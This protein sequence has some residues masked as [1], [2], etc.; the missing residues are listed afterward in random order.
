M[1]PRLRARGALVVAY[2]DTS[3]LLELKPTDRRRGTRVRRAAGAHPRATTSDGAKATSS[4][5]INPPE[6][7]LGTQVRTAPPDSAAVLRRYLPAAIVATALVIVAPALIVSAL[8]PNGGVTMAIVSAAAAVGISLVIATALA[9]LWKRRAR[10][11]DVV[12]ADLMLWGWLRRYRAERRLSQARDLFESARRA[13][14]SVNIEML[15]G[16][17]RLLE[18][19]DP[20]IHGHSQRVARHSVRIGRAMGLSER[21]VAKLRTAA[22]VHDVGKLYTPRAILVNPDRLTE[23]EF[24]VIKRHTTCGAE[25]VSVVGDAEITAMVRHHH[26]R[27]DGC[28][29]PDALAGVAIPLGAR[30]IAVA[31][32]FDA[33]TS[34]RPYRSAASQKRALGVLE[35]EAGAQLD[36]AAVAAFKH[37]YSA[38]RSVAWYAF[39]TTAVQRAVAALQSLVSSLGLGAASVA[40]LAPA[41]GAAGVLAVS[42]GLFRTSHNAQP[43]GDS[44][45]LLQPLVG[46]GEASAGANRSAGEGTGG[47]AVDPQNGA[48]R[49][50]RHVVGGIN[51]PLRDPRGAAGSPLAGAPSGSGQPRSPSP[52]GSGSGGGAPGAGPTSPEGGSPLGETPESPFHAPGH[53]AQSPTAGHDADGQHADREHTGCHHTERHHTDRQRARRDRS[54]RHGARRDRSERDGSARHARALSRS[55]TATAPALRRDDECEGAADRAERCGRVGHGDRPGRRAGRHDRREPFGGDEAD[56]LRRHAVELHGRARREADAVDRNRLADCA[57]FGAPR[58]GQRRREPG[59]ARGNPAGS[60]DHDFAGFGAVGHG[61]FELARR[62]DREACREFADLHFADVR[63]AAAF[64]RQG[65]C[66]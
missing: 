47:P 37:G 34:D 10:S 28:G 31:D 61:H 26:E 51:A 59:F 60:R 39:A 52:A 35:A 50:A 56:A 46:A 40:T 23:E 33:I 53:P 13:G 25:M 55:T 41:L 44:A 54:Q 21:E 57:M 8:V 48:Q 62:D 3:M 64:E 12:F 7:E 2:F 29:Y 66:R 19:R 18:A 43:S 32:T 58:D 17:S 45:G 4:S 65:R 6:P 9:A 36:A 22:E 42:P 20:Y 30:I 16:L 14:P 1:R 5:P 38:R 11:R 63:Q 49:N 24:A 27:I 15:L